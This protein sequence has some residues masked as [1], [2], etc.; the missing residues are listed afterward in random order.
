MKEQPYAGFKSFMEHINDREDYFQPDM[1]P[2]AL[3]YV[4]DA[5][6]ELF[7]RTHMVARYNIS[8]HELNKRTV[9]FVNA[10]AQAQMLHR[11]EDILTEDEADIVRRG[12]NTKA[13]SVPRHTHPLQYRY[14]TGFE[15]LLGYL[16]IK[17]AYDRL[18]YILRLCLDNDISE[19]NNIIPD[20]E[21]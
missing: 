13:S 1:S 17:G 15:T 2:L 5:I 19:S 21:P 20:H 4:G 8:P 11:L 18:L 3:A 10:K 9:A 16:Y 6:Y 14:A 12:R 7:I